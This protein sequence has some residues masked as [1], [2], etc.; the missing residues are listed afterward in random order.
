M[1]ILAPLPY[2]VAILERVTLVNGLPVA[3]ASADVLYG[4]LSESEPSSTET[5][6]RTQSVQ[7]LRYPYDSIVD[8]PPRAGSTLQIDN[9]VYI[10]TNQPSQ[11][12]S[13]TRRVGWRVQ[14]SSLADAFPITGEAT[15]QD[16]TDYGPISF[17]MWSSLDNTDTSGEREERQGEAPFSA[18]AILKVF[19][20][21]LQVGDERWRPIW[22]LLDA[23]E[24]VTKLR[25]RNTRGLD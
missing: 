17:S 16:G 11:L 14:V 23:E 20:V 18:Y 25:L 6:P 24:G 3:T 15:G 21:Y 8:P 19:N 12:K 2:R 1:S 4:Q 7:E 9:D 10:Q 22:C 5:S 13:G